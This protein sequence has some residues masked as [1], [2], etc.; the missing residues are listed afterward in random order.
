ML[1][2]IE[3]LKD[4]LCDIKLLCFSLVPKSVLRTLKKSMLGPLETDPDF[5]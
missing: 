2:L 4:F 5:L 1:F 3:H